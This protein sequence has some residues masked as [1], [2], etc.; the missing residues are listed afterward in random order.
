MRKILILLALIYITSVIFC[1]DSVNVFYENIN[2]F[3][4]K[5]ISIDTSDSEVVI[6]TAVAQRFPNG[7]ESWG[8]FI[9]R[10][11][12]DAAINGTYFCPRTSKP[13][14]DIV[15]ENQ[16]YYRGVAGTAFCVLPGNKMTMRLGPNQAK[17]NWQDCQT[18]VCAGPRLLTGGSVTITAREEGFRDPRV[19]GSAPRSAI[20][21]DRNGKLFLL[22][23]DQNI[24]LSNLAYVCQKLGASSAMAMDGGNSSGLYA[25]GRTL[26]YPG[27]SLANILCIYKT[28]QKFYQY[29]YRLAPNINIKYPSGFNKPQPAYYSAPSLLTALGNFAAGKPAN[30]SQP[31]S[32]S[33]MYIHSEDIQ[34]PEIFS[35]TYNQITDVKSEQPVQQTVIIPVKEIP[36]INENNKMKPPSFKISDQNPVEKPAEKKIDIVAVKP[37]I[38]VIKENHVNPV[39]D[40]VP[41]PM[42]VDEEDNNVIVETTVPVNDKLPNIET[43]VDNKTKI[44]K[45]EAADDTGIAKGIY[46]LNVSIAPDAEVQLVKLFIDGILRD[47]K[48][49]QS[50]SKNWNTREYTNSLH[51]IEV[52]AF[53]NNQIIAKDILRIQVDN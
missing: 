52:V 16:H 36:V 21:W 7:L 50:F 1:A 32:L 8:S 44:V 17:A 48:S 18:V 30:Y 19:L 35:S 2:G 28:R 13:V 10:L 47:M 12:P 51:T 31:K 20:A 5:Y 4:V 29:A 27:R 39:I 40:V 45:L 23:I 49:S 15:V 43:K 41:L 46:K 11:N 53:K 22:T 38:P 34:V 26:S 42:P 25:E 9:N 14:G 37:N 6:T 24:S 3:K 33:E